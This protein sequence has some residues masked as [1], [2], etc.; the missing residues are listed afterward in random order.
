MARRGFWESFLDLVFGESAR[1]EADRPL[2]GAP[3]LANW[4]PTAATMPNPACSSIPS[5]WGSFW[6][7]RR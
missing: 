5:H 4:L 3:M 2:L 6:N 1:P 7:S